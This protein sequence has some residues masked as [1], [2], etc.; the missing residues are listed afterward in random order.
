MSRHYYLDQKFQFH[1]YR[2]HFDK[3]H[4]R[5]SHLHDQTGHLLYRGRYHHRHHRLLRLHL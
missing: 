4:L 1:M 3:T 2:D 5:Q